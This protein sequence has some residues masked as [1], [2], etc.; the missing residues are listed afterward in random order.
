MT[1]R[2]EF[3]KKTAVAGAAVAL[4][5]GSVTGRSTSIDSPAPNDP[6]DTYTVSARTAMNI[7][8]IQQRKITIPDTA[9]FKVLKGDFHIHTLFSDGQV[10]PADRV[11]EA[12]QNGLDVIAL[13]DHIEVRPYFS[14]VGRW[15][16]V[17]EQGLNHNLSY[18]IAK[19]EA[20]RK[21]LLLIPGTEIT[22]FKMPPGH[23]NVLFA[24]DVNP[25]A[26]AVDDWR[27]MFQIAVDQGAFMIWNHPGWQSQ[28]GGIEQ[29]APLRFTVEHEEAYKRGWMHG[30][31]IFNSTEHYPV[32]LDWCN[33]RDLALFANSDIHPSELSQYGIHNPARPITLV[34]AKERTLESVRE[35]LFAKRT[36]AWAAHLIWGRDP[37]LPE[38]FNASVEMKTLSPGTLELTNKSSLPI[39]VSIGGMAV[40]LFQDQKQQVY[41]AEGCRKLTVVNWMAGMNKPLEIPLPITPSN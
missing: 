3:L 31:E 39:T 23:F 6:V 17:D 27:K 7:P 9:G 30:I 1:S 20:E 18:E 5:P 11:N 14:T 34:L 35:A 21:N 32:V 33:K 13:T 36:I 26:A 24:Q 22:K 10:M 15:K 37:W 8:S 28:H 40:N 2:R 16:L 4:A 12:V 41:R 38:L 25:I 29:G 19:P